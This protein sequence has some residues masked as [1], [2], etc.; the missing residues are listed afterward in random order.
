MS[1]K[2]P[3]PIEAMIGRSGRTTT[4]LI[5]EGI[6]QVGTERWKAR[7][8]SSIDKNEEIVV[9]DTEGLTLVVTRSHIDHG[10]HEILV[11]TGRN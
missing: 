6:V 5:P 2:A 8:I 4:P 9:V 10:S 3:L 11:K 1:K 7:A